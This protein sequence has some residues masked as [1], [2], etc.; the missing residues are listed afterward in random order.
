MGFDNEC[1]VNIQ[2]LAGE[3]FCPV[4]RLLV[5]P[6][7]ALQS[8]CT[9]L[10]CKPCLT[11]VVST[12]KACPYDGY[13]VTEADSKP[14]TE[15]NKTLA[16]TIGKITVHCL[17]HRS[18]CTWQGTLSECTSHCSG[19]AF[20]NS[21]VVCNRCGIQIVHRQVQEHAQN[22]PGVQGQAQQVSTTQDPST[23]TVGS[24]TDQNQN[25]APV[26]ATAAQAAVST[27]MPG[28]VSNQQPNLT[29]QTQALVQTA[30]QPTAEQW[31]QQQQY[32]QYYQQYPGQDPYQQQYQHY[33]PYQQSMVPQYQQAYSQPQ[34]QSQSQPQAQL[35]PQPQPQAQH[36]SQQPQL[37][38]PQAQ[39]QPLSHIQ[40]PV[41]P[42]SQNQMQ[43]QQQPQQLQPAVQPHGQTSH[44]PGHSLPQSQTQ[45]YPY[46]Q[47]QLHSVQ[48]QP[49]QP[50]QIPPY[51]QPLPQVQHSQPQ[52]QQPIQKYPVPQSQVH[53]QLQ[54]NAPVQHPSQLPMPPPHPV[55]PSVQPQVQNAAT[56]SVTGHHSYPQP[57]PHPNMQ[58]G[59]PQHPMHG[60]P[61][62]G[63]QPHAQHPVQMQNQF[64]PQ[65]P[66]MRPNQSHAMFPNQ[67]SSVQ[68][69]T[70]PPLQQQPVYSHNQQPGQ[71]NQR[72]T[73]QPVQ[74]I[75]QQ[76]PFAQH[77]MPMPSH[78]RPPGPGPAHSFP[79]HVYPQPQGN[80]APSNNIQQNQ[81]QNAGGR[82]LVPNH[83][84]HLQPFAQS[85]NT[86]PVRHGQNGA[87]YLLENQK[88]LAGTNNQVQL[89][90]ELQS[91]AP[92]TIERHGDVV[93]QQIDTAAGKLG[94]NFKD[95]DS[96]SG[97]T[98]ELKSEK[99]EASLKPVEVGN[100]LNNED[101]HSIK[102]SVPNANAVEN[103]DSLNKNLGM[104]AAA[105]STWKPSVSTKPGGAM[106]GVQN[107]TNEHS[108]QGNEF[109]EGHPPKTETK[110][111]ES[112]TD[113]SQNDDNSAASNTQ[114]NGGFAQLSHS[115]AFTDQS[116]HQQPMTNYGPSVQ[117]RS[118]A[119]L[120]SQL[121][122]PTIPNQ[123]LSSL[124]SSALVRNHGSAHD[125]HTGQPLAESFPP[126]MFKQPQD[127]DI[128][129]GRS[130]QPQS[131]GP[132]QPFNQVHEPPFR[133][134]TSNLSRLGG[135]QFGAPLPGDLHGRM[136]VNI[137]PHGP[138]GFSLHD[139]RF[140]PFLVSN[141][142]NV[143]RREY[144]DDLKKF[145]RMPL[146]AESISKFGNYSLSAHESGKRSVGIHD[147]VIKK[148]GSTLHPGYLG[149]GPG[150][151]RHHM[152][153]MTPRSPVGEYAEMSSRRLGAHSGSLVGK[154][155]IDDF[156]GRVSRHFGGEF[157]D[158]R[159]PHLP[160]H[161]RRDEFD[162]FGN[163]RMGEHPRSG[164]FIGQDEFAGHFR[165]GD[166]LGPHN[167][168][169]HLQ[170]GEPV[171]FG[172][173]PGHMRAVEHGSFRSFESFAKGNRSG[174]PQLGEPG[175]RSSFSL[176]GFPNDAGFLTGDIRSF[177]NLR[178]R[179]TSSMGW[180]RICKVDCETVEG[181][182]LHSQ[183]KEHQKMAMDMVKTIK[184]NAKKQKIPSEQPTVDDGN[185]THSTGFE[186][187]GNKH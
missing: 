114:S 71:I 143:D 176:P 182:D 158:S 22:C 187:R 89:P 141:Q 100:M 74:Q 79:K 164:D 155:G 184:Q 12:T 63:P 163:F 159:F 11:Y 60:H 78:L 9:H 55:T 10:Y 48:P 37:Q 144:D 81:S 7:E 172:A 180:C 36:Q 20:G 127:S 138:E 58:P 94:K 99:F 66:T 101:P 68:G 177:D 135:P 8:Q 76:Q 41:V 146:D 136:A 132:P 4:C 46:P 117:Q 175:F 125:P 113:K 103:G 15:S 170:L 118:S 133:A 178:R 139:D 126:T 64:P 31:Y 50:T 169:R 80:I 45:P 111:P 2:S 171:G 110:L 52:I 87:G 150:Y 83:A 25:A 91:R 17:Y 162:G 1:I 95:L 98:N 21:P 96:V 109:Q 134:G 116:K 160:S 23:T 86:I 147:D 185:K 121:P 59:V 85:S 105:E 6:N 62:S 72:P 3:Y 51:Q 106:H 130:F 154:S 24:S 120:G 18:G 137:P 149:P 186:G 82:P 42:P 49:Q 90:S 142:Q 61:Q 39:S 38:Q 54:P 75:P 84:G 108:V 30:G 53:A 92:E 57:L 145:S 29:P 93:E 33:Y 97:P 156:D 148:S 165:R 174:H 69:Q 153:G 119:M 19:C 56:P 34:P 140:K 152:D 5:F 32:Q 27:T 44:A 157:R 16:E 166:P 28:Q 26:A 115:S 128:T 107:D 183:T 123:P 47:V 173:H 70:T 104:G 151:G 88:L 124:H 161:L 181:L 67:Q 167:F 129:P 77:Q 14:L 65:I 131:L 179:K 13:L 35:Q 112:E 43:V 102:T 73:L 168:P 122:H 40:A